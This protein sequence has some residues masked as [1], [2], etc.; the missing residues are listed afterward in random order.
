MSRNGHTP[1]ELPDPHKVGRWIGDMIHET[2]VS[3]FRWASSTAPSPASTPPSSSID[4]KRILRSMEA[5]TRAVQ[6]LTDRVETLSDRMDRIEK[7]AKPKTTSRSAS[8]ELPVSKGKLLSAKYQELLPQILW[9]TRKPDQ[10]I[11]M[12]TE[13]FAAQFL[14]MLKANKVE[15]DFDVDVVVRTLDN[16]GYAVDGMIVARPEPVTA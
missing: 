15:P 5:L 1:E 11:G 13:E 9:P 16:L 2:T 12:K 14:T 7:G 3:I 8:Q 4:E 10:C 6:S